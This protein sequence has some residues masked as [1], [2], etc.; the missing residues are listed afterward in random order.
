MTNAPTQRPID[1]AHYLPWTRLL[2]SFRMATDPRKL[3]LAAAAVALFWC[4]DQGLRML[5]FAPTVPREAP[6][7]H[8]VR[9]IPLVGWNGHAGE[10]FVEA[11]RRGFLRLEE[12]VLSPLRPLLE[13]VGLPVYEARTWPVVALAWTR[14]FWALLLWSLFG[15]AIARIA[16]VEFARDERIGIAESLKFAARRLGSLFAA[17]LLPI[18]GVLL[19]WGACSLG[20]LVG[21]VPFGDWVVGGLW[22]LALL[23]A[24]LL[25]LILI[26]TALGWPLMVAAIAT[27]GSDAFDGFSRSFSYLYGRPWL[28]VWYAG[29]ALSL[30]PLLVS[31]VD[32]LALGVAGVA[33]RTV[34]SGMGS[35]AGS[36]LY[37]A[38]P[39]YFSPTDSSSAD[40]AQ[41]PG[42]PS[43]LV[44][45]WLAVVAAAAVGFASSYFWTA[46]T[47]VY[48]LLRRADDATQ[49]D[50]VWLGDEQE[51]DD[52]LPLAGI[53]STDQPVTERSHHPTI[54]PP[55]AA[56]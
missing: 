15:G 50:E 22:G 9:P 53:A 6:P 49:F 55:A 36:A 38:A 5:P 48:F 11:P 40:G 44:S 14:L 21:R 29:L 16:A 34:E 2:R 43:A 8:A 26:A 23:A 25:V 30:G 37:A 13:V 33:A 12:R 20:G 45:A 31:A 39:E 17:P 47:I 4:G 1:Y 56:G 3:T 24:L 35:G 10:S 52:L 41:P 32:T 46:A 54:N 18:L 27:E 19:L 51:E 7:W 28:F 42:G